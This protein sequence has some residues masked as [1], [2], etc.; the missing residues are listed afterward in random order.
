MAITRNTQVQTEQAMQHSSFDADFG[1]N[2]FELLGYDSISDS[3]KRLTANALG[4]Y[5]VNDTV[6]DG[7]VTYIGREDVNGDWFVQKIDETSGRSIRYATVK[8]NA[9]ITNY[10][11]AWAAYLTLTYN[12]YSVAF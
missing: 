6:E 7:Q 10:T 11:D 4:E 1:V 2:A 12:I 8:N 5:M 9:T 3:V